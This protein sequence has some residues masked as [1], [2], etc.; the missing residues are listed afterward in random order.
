MD[1]TKIALLVLGFLLGVSG[2][3]IVYVNT[4]KRK[5]DAIRELMRAEIQAF[6]EACDSAG[7]M[8]LWDSSTVEYI[9][10]LIIESYSHDRDRFVAVQKPSARQELYKFYLEV[11]GI[12]SLIEIHRKTPVTGE[13]GSSA[14]IGPGTYEGMVKR[15]KATLETLK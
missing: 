11:N 7:K 9:S 10:R 15:S 3:F 13:N 12:L 1:L 8:K 14:A 5:K 2:Q 4:E 6:I